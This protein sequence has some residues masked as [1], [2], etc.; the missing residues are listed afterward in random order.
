M[1][2][3]LLLNN[4]LLS[5]KISKDQELIQSDP[6]S[7]KAALHVFLNYITFRDLNLSIHFNIVLIKLFMPVSV[8]CRENCVLKTSFLSLV[9]YFG[10]FLDDVCACMIVHFIHKCSET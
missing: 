2:S 9:N 8:S 3:E 4:S 5:K 6:I 10:L 1:N 7:H